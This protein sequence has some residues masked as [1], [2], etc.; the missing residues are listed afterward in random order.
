MGALFRESGRNWAIFVA[1]W[2]NLLAF[3]ASTLYFQVTTFSSHPITSLFWILFYVGGFL[4]LTLGL[5]RRGDIL[6][7]KRVL[8]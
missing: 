7:N 6:L 1:M 2:C 5:R 3:A 8:I 4:L